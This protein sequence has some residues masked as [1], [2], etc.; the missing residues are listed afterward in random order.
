MA[1][2]KNLNELK[3][4]AE[5]AFRYYNLILKEQ[6]KI[7]D[8][9]QKGMIKSFSDLSKEVARL[10]GDDIPNV[11]HNIIDA[12]KE[13]EKMSAE[14]D[15]ITDSLLSSRAKL[16]AF[17]RDTET[18]VELKRESFKIQ[19]RALN[20]DTLSIQQMKKALAITTKE[21]RIKTKS[22]GL[23]SKEVTKQKVLL[24]T[25]KNAGDVSPTG[26]KLIEDTALSKLKAVQKLIETTEDKSKEA[27]LGAGSAGDMIKDLTDEYKEFRLLTMRKGALEKRIKA[28]SSDDSLSP[29]NKSSVTKT[30]G[31]KMSKVEEGFDKL[32]LTSYKEYED[33]I[34]KASKEMSKLESTHVR[35]NAAAKKYKSIAKDIVDNMSSTEHQLLKQLKFYRDI[36]DE[37]TSIET[38]SGLLIGK[39]QNISEIN[40]D[41]VAFYRQMLGLLDAQQQATGESGDIEYKMFKRRAGLLVKAD[42]IHDDIQEKIKNQYQTLSD[43]ASLIPGIGPKLADNFDSARDKVS[44]LASDMYQQFSVTFAKTGNA[45]KALGDA[46]SVALSRPGVAL[47]LG[48]GAALLVAAALYNQIRKLS[49]T[50]EEVSSNTGLT[51]SQAFILEKSALR[52]QIRFD[53]MLASME[54][55]REAQKGIVNEAGFFLQIQNDVL[56]TVANTGRAFGYGAELAGQLQ[57]ELMQVSGGSEVLAANTQ[58]ALASIAEAEGLAPGLVAKD[59]VEN[60]ELVARYFTGYPRALA[61]TVVEI[62]KMGLGLSQM[63]GMMQHLLDY[64]KSITAEFEASVALGRHVNVGKARDLLLNEDILG[65]MTEMRKQAG[66]LAEFEDMGFA[67]RQLMANAMGLSVK[68]TRKML[69]V[70]E[71]LSGETEA[72]QSVALEHYDTIQRLSGGN[73]SLFKVQAKNVQASQQF[74]T[75]ILKIKNTF[76]SALLP[77]LEA[78]M[79]LLKLAANLISGFAKVLDG[80]LAPVNILLAAFSDLTNLDFSFSRTGESLKNAVPSVKE[81]GGRLGAGL[82]TAGLIGAGY[83]GFKGIQKMRGKGGGGKSGGGLLSKIPL[84]GGGRGS[85]AS[86]PMFVSVVGG[87]GL[88]GGGFGGRGS[89]RRVGKGRVSR[90]AVMKRY[91]RMKAGKAGRTVGRFGSVGRMAS[92]GIGKV[93]RLGGMAAAAGGGLLSKGKGLLSSAGKVGGKALGKIGGKVGL[94]GVGKGVGK[95]ALK[96][97]PGVSLL[98]GGGFAVQRA[99]QGDYLGALGE[100]A[101][102][103]VGTIPGVGTAASIGIDAALMGR[104][105]HRAKNPGKTGARNKSNKSMATMKPFGKKRPG[106]N[107]LMLGIATAGIGSVVSGIRQMSGSGSDKSGSQETPQTS[108]VL[109]KEEY[110]KMNND[111]IKAVDSVRSELSVIRNQPMKAFIDE[112]QQRQ[113]NRKF[114]AK[115]SN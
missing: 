1:D 107:P 54:N 13:L 90:G 98:A 92:K 27:L 28:V 38:K 103:V 14:S 11:K 31:G 66:S 93:G 85:S 65:A 87:G 18:L 5:A 2:D 88:F 62:Q 64:E 110:I 22:A 19:R 82:K 70:S 61:N 72:M 112:E 99:M 105:I 77:L 94:K 52:T 32:S 35:L 42:Q 60:S 96:K 39:M 16:Q 69:F 115:N 109:T 29:K 80:M 25:L 73:E 95:S 3:K 79:P 76:K 15:K 84:I 104:D 89:K 67:R 81:D 58:V 9:I 51:A 46:M 10:S 34:A 102:G 86:K 8:A 111:L 74:E 101:S 24:E 83:L 37:A 59:V 106:I 75:S 20:S 57:T 63:G 71:K 48:L 97:I 55:L 68:E 114:K 50:M 26:M 23:S 41:Q 49:Q 21:L 43:I 4:Q 113:M 30:L 33:V 40:K 7:N 17:L 36:H 44:A 47:A 53:N 6:D 45:S 100:L 91:A 108:E 12:T 78:M 56:N